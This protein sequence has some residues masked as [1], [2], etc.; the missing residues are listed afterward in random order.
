MRRNEA[1]YLTKSSKFN[2]E[3]ISPDGNGKM[4]KV[5]NQDNL[6]MCIISYVYCICKYIYLPLFDTVCFVYHKSHQVF[7]VNVRLKHLS[8]HC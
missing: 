1:T 5:N 8:I 2:P 3:C 6:Y 7:T 4:G